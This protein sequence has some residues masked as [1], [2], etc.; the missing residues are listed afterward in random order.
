MSANPGKVRKLDGISQY[1]RGLAAG[2]QA[3]EAEARERER[4]IWAY[5]GHERRAT[6]WVCSTVGA[7]SGAIVAGLVAWLL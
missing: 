4:A 7:L 2:R 1:A 5:T 3:A 6:A